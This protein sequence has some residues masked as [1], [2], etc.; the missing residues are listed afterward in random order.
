MRK[1]IIAGNWKMHKTI[2][3]ALEFVN[4]IKDKVNSDKVEAVIC[5]PFTLLKD[6]KE[7][8][9]GTNIKIGAQNMHFEEKGAFTG[10]VSPLM[11]KEIDMDYVV[12]GHSERRQYFNET[13]ETVNKKVL[14]A[15]EVG[16]DPILCVGET[17]EQ[18]EAGKT[19]D[20]CKVQVEKALENVL[21]DDLAKVVVAYEPI[22]AIGTGKTATA[23]DANDVISYIREVIKGLYGEL[24]NEVRIQYGGSVKPS[25]VAEIM[26]QSDID[27]AL[28]G[29]ASLAS[30]DYLGL[31]NF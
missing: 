15:L 7:A 4:E 11:L 16:I 12:I 31:V 18:R 29:G 30:N 8:T 20:V 26:G 3:E 24:A 22:W 27:G 17:L 5:A 13:D 10:E 19:K 9:K 21:K 23:E 6:L 14:K 28:V 25:N 1:P 2:K